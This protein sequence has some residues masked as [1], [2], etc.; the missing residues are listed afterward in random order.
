MTGDIPGMFKRG[1]KREV[2]WCAACVQSGLRKLNSQGAVPILN[3]FS[4]YDSIVEM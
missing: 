2:V 4:S 1:S 3:A